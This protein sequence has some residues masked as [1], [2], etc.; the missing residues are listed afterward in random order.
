MGLFMATA[1]VLSFMLAIATLF[2]TSSALRSI[3]RDALPAHERV[4]FLP[5]RDWYMP[6]NVLG[7]TRPLGVFRK[8]PAT[9]LAVPAFRA[10]L[11][12][13]RVLSLVLVIGWLALALHALAG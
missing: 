3:V 11:A 13:V 12:I 10:C 4:L 6:Q 5:A 8:Q 2:A 1:A 9:L 7:S